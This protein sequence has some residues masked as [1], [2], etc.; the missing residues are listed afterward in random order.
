MADTETLAGWRRDFQHLYNRL[1]NGR[2]QFRAWFEEVQLFKL[3]TEE[4]RECVAYIKK[5][6][7]RYWRLLVQLPKVEY[8]SAK[9][10]EH[11]T[12]KASKLL[13]LSGEINLLGVRI[14]RDIEKLH[15]LSKRSPGSPLQS[16]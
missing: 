3:E 15:S 10:L 6:E 5:D 12:G 9:E 11:R 13:E 7:Q 8:F 4:M 2:K 16:L 14:P 1:M